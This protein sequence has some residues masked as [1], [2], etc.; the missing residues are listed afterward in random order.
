MNLSIT[1]TLDPTT[2]QISLAGPLENTVICIGMLEM[3]K[4]SIIEYA[5]KKQQ[6]KTILDPN[7]GGI[8]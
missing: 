1:I 5:H 8:A 3:A 6:G 2:G 7:T 4:I